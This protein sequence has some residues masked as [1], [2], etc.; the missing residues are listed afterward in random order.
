MPLSMLEAKHPKALKPFLTCSLVAL[1]QFLLRPIRT[2]VHWSRYVDCKRS[3]SPLL[4]YLK[5]Q[6]LGCISDCFIHPHVCGRAS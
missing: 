5:G 6:F 3:P 1:L 2:F 4:W